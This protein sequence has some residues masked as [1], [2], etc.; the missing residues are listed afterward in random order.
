ML[1]SQ[2]VMA[3]TNGD[4]VNKCKQITAFVSYRS[5]LWTL[6]IYASSP[7][8]HGGCQNVWLFT[9]Y[10][11]FVIINDRVNCESFAS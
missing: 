11:S 4:V 1:L 6:G 9:R 8:I 7:H 5:F 10:C 2:S 3:L